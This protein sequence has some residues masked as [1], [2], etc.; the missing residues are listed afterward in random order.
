MAGRPCALRLRAPFRAVFAILA[1]S[2]LVLASPAGAAVFTVTKTADGNDGACNADCS[3]REAVLAANAVP[4]STVIVPAGYYRLSL[5]PPARVAGTPGD[6]SGGNLVVNAPMTIQGAG[7]DV[8]IIDPRPSADEPAVDRV[9][10]VWVDGDLTLSNVTITGSAL[11]ELLAPGVG[12][13]HGAA[14]GVSA[15]KLRIRDSAIRDNWTNGAGGALAITNIERTPAEVEI[16]R[17]QITDNVARGAGGAIFS[18]NSTLTI[19]D[20]TIARNRSLGVGGGG[21]IM[22]MN[23]GDRNFTPMAL[24]RVVRSTI[25]YNQSG[26][27]EAEEPINGVG[28]GGGIFNSNGRVEIENST[29]VH[30]RAQGLYLGEV[31]GWLPDNGRGG[32]VATWTPGLDEPEDTTV[33]VNSTIAWN[34]GKAGSQLHMK[35]DSPHPNK[36]ELAN[37]LVIGD[38]SDPNCRGWGG[39][40]GFLSHGGN[41]SS[42]ASPC[43]L[44]LASDRVNAGGVVAGELA[45][46]GGPTETL[47]LLD[48]SPALALGVPDWCPERDQ[49]G[50]LRRVPCDSGAVE[51]V[52]VPEAGAVAGAAAAAGALAGL[53]ARRRRA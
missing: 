49:R 42:D 16:T 29:I 22:N 24:L 25:A 11:P 36:V 44:D 35:A 28:V 52:A 8:T 23:T 26:D 12:A 37:T 3:L 53:R 50:A 38:G 27:P 20:S 30:N 7:R 45:D 5:P 43:Q 4:G 21:G 2:G 6:G 17:T 9:L 33:I 15:G 34:E 32:G 1:A 40:E 19:T 31:I 14:V 18:V 39:Q 13:D 51:A 46:L 48:G 47:A 10:H 41:V